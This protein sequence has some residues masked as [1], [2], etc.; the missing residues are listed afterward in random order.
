[1]HEDSPFMEEIDLATN[2]GFGN[3]EDDPMISYVVWQG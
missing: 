3:D 1:M 2:N